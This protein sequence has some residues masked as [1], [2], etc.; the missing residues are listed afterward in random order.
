MSSEPRIEAE[1]WTQAGVRQTEEVE[2][3]TGAEKDDE[4]D[5]VTVEVGLPAEDHVGVG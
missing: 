2:V 4:T 5:A 3:G 1:S